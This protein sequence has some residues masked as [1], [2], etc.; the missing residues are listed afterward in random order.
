MVGDDD[1]LDDLT[2]LMPLLDFPPFAFEDL[3]ADNVSLGD[4]VSAFAPVAR[5]KIVM[6]FID[7]MINRSRYSFVQW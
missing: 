3:A 7:F 1:V 6:H 2:P 4:C 5:R